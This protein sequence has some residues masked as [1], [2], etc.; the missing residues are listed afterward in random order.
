MKSELGLIT[1]ISTLFCTGNMQ[2]WPKFNVLDVKLRSRFSQ[3]KLRTVITTEFWQ[4]LTWY[5]WF[6]L[7][8]NI[9]ADCHSSEEME[10]EKTFSIFN[11]CFD[12]HISPFKLSAMIS[13]QQKGYFLL[14]TL[15]WIRTFFL[16]GLKDGNSEFAWCIE[17]I[18][19]EREFC[20]RKVIGHVSY[21]K[22]YCCSRVLAEDP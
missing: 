6:R 20:C 7:G 15:D 5:L 9:A 11:G 3:N 21:G 2:N 8:E 13:M 16:Y 18:G 17:T 14:T 4:L 10:A 19:H 12:V 22:S 1:S